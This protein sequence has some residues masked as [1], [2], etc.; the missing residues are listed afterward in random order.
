MRAGK[1]V[2]RSTKAR[3]LT[4]ARRVEAKWLMEISEA[5]E[6]IQ[7][8]LQQRQRPRTLSIM[9]DQFFAYLDTHIEKKRTREFYK[10]SW[11]PLIRNTPHT[12]NVL[13]KDIATERIQLWAQDRSKEVGPARVNASLRTLRRFL[14]LAM[15]W[16]LIDKLP[17]ISLL[18]GEK[19]RDYVISETTLAKMVAHKECPELLKRL[20]PFLV[21]TGLRIGEGTDLHWEHVDLKGNGSIFITKGKTKYARRKIP[22]TTRAKD[23][24]VK[25]K[26]HKVVVKRPTTDEPVLNPDGPVYSPYVWPDSEGRKVNSNWPSVQLRR[27]RDKMKLPKDLVLHSTRHTFCTRLAE[28][29]VSA[30][31][32]QRLAGHGSIVISQRYTHLQGKSLAQAIAKMEANVG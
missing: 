32:L 21:D 1:V 22:L 29:G 3:N 2:V 24:L 5:G 9:Q 20:L 13:L 28:A 12:L 27:L 8:L 30:F 26:E 31:E 6:I 19:M 17:K 7:P 4:D 18:P 10:D 11:R 14:R 16:N 23:I 15:D 25:M